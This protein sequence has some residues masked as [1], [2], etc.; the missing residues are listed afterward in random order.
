MFPRQLLM[1]LLDRGGDSDVDAP[2]RAAAVDVVEV[3][4]A[5]VIPQELKL[6]GGSVT[7]IGNNFNISSSAN[8]W[9]C[10]LLQPCA[11]CLLRRPPDFNDSNSLFLN[12]QLTSADAVLLSPSLLHCSFSAI[13]ANAKLPPLPPPPP[14]P[15]TSFFDCP[16]PH[17]RFQLR[18]I[19]LQ[20]PSTSPGHM[21]S[22]VWLVLYA[23]HLPR[24]LLSLQHPPP[25]SSD[26]ARCTT[27]FPPPSLWQSLEPE[28][29]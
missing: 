13:Q 19:L 24:H 27:A 4:V 3:E 29:A 21:F 1:S 18:N 6:G 5:A 26:A 2:T 11:S 9:S 10:V 22:I 28:F 8:C 14:L 15:T 20:S 25:L 16:H 12:R 23:H 17:S 7:I